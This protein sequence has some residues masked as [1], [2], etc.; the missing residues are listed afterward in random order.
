MSKVDWRRIDESWLGSAPNGSCYAVLLDDEG[1][2]AMSDGRWQIGPFADPADAMQLI[3][4]REM[5]L[6]LAMAGSK[7]DAGI[8]VFWIVRGVT[9]ADEEVRAIVRCSSED[10]AVGR[11]ER[12]Y[13]ERGPFADVRAERLSRMP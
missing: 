3:E 1:W 10:F 7:P 6:G 2:W 9:R 12:A 4:L 8:P 13:G 11:F 5:D